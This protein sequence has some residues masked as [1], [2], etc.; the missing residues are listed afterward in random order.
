MILIV[1]RFNH[2]KKYVGKKRVIQKLYNK[3]IPGKLLQDNIF[4]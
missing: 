1:S 4:C 3:H 2:S